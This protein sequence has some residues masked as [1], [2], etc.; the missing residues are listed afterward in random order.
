MIIF[1]FVKINFLPQNVDVKEEIA[2]LVLEA[3]PGTKW[4][5]LEGKFEGTGEKIGKF[6]FSYFLILSFQGSE[7]FIEFVFDISEENTGDIIVDHA[8]LVT[9]ENYESCIQIVN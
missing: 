1:N 3:V 9:N 2:V 7:K 5:I 6:W 4:N 8:F